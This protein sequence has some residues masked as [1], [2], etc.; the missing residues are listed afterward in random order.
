[1]CCS[2]R[3]Y[4]TCSV[5][6]PSHLPSLSSGPSWFTGV[7]THVWFLFPSQA[8]ANRRVCLSPVVRSDES[9]FG[10]E[11]PEGGHAQLAGHGQVWHH[12]PVLPG[13]LHRSRGHAEINGPAEIPAPKVRARAVTL[14]EGGKKPC[15][16]FATGASL[17]SCYFPFLC[18]SFL[19]LDKQ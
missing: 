2:Q 14:G 7:E 4:R 16:L 6:V 3:Q 17:S 11:V 9:A 13:G 10:R 1:M 18:F 8:P 19:S 12:V 15:E 5:W